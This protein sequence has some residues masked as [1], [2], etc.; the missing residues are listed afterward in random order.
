MKPKANNLK[1]SH[2]IQ[3]SSKY[4][5]NDFSWFN[6]FRKITKC[7]YNTC[8]HD[9]ITAAAVQSSGSVYKKQQQPKKNNQIYLN[10]SHAS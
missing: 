2:R 1:A 9:T 10:E 3:D 4:K 8:R 7:I 6:N 5:L